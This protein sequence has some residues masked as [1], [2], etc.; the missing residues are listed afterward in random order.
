MREQGEEFWRWLAE[1][2]HVYVCGNAK[3]MA[4]DV[5][6]ALHAVIVEYGRQAVDQA[7]TYVCSRDE[8]FQAI[9]ARR[10]LT[11]QEGT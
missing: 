11:S 6:E 9:P 7:A 3:R 5:D 2:A 1:G 8:T 10:V 4:K